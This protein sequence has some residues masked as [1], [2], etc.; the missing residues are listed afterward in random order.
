MSYAENSPIL[1]MFLLNTLVSP[2]IKPAFKSNI[3]FDLP[4]LGIV[5]SSTISITLL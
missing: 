1:T 2:S 4:E 3:N 5:M